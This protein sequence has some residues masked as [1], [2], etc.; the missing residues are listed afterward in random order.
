MNLNDLKNKFTP[1][2]LDELLYLGSTYY[3]SEYDT[4]AF[5]FLIQL[6]YPNA[7]IQLNYPNAIF[8]EKKEKME[9]I[10]QAYDNYDPEAIGKLELA[11]YVL[12]LSW[13]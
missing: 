5:L 4:Y 12:Y 2:E 6:N 1:Q 11:R 13:A 3:F 8:Q 7:M 9:E 10:M